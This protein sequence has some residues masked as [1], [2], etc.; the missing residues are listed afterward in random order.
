M[1]IAL[2]TIWHSS[3]YGAEFQTYATVRKLQEMGHEVQ[4]IDFRLQESNHGSSLKG[5]VSVFLHDCAPAIRNFTKFWERYIPAT[6]HYE[7][8]EDLRN[9]PPEANLYLVGSDQVWNPQITKEKASTYFLDFVPDG[10]IMASYASSF[11]TDQW[12]GDEALTAIVTQ[13]LGKFKAIGCREQQG[14]LLLNDFF[15]LEATHVLDPSLLHRD[16]PELTGKIRPKNT[17]AYYQLFENTQ[18]KE[19]AK[20][21]ATE[22]GLDFVDVNHNSQLTPTFTWNRRSVGQWIQ[23][24]AESSFVITHSF[25]GLVLCLLYHRPFVIVYDKGNLS[26]RLVSLLRLV[27]MEDRLFTSIVSAEQSDVWTRPI[28]YEQVDMIIAREREKSMD[29]LQRI[30]DMQ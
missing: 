21:K 7:S 29:F 6:R 24:M 25:H 30:T 26:S 11:G 4:V 28:D 14:C 12:Q 1:R 15:H 27:G 20:R 10:K 19:F 3:N 5:R 9:N 8:V 17:L 18:M 23:A 16:Y 13:Q 2:L 22:M